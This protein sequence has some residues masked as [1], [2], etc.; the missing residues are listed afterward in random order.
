MKKSDVSLHEKYS[1]AIK[2]MKEAEAKPRGQERQDL[3]MVSRR[4]FEEVSNLVESL[5]IFSSNELL[6]DVAS[7]DLKYMLVPFHIA[8]ILISSEIGSDRLSVFK[9][10]KQ[11]MLEFLRIAQQYKIYDQDNK[12]L[13]AEIEKLFD[14][15][16]PSYDHKSQITLENAMEMRNLKIENY[17]KRKELDD[18]LNQLEEMLNLGHQIEDEIVREYY[19]KLLQRSVEDSVESLKNEIRMGLMFESRQEPM[20]SNQPSDHIDTKVSLPKGGLTIV[21]DQEQKKVFGLGYPSKPTLTVDEFIGQ[22]IKSGDLAFQS[23]KEIYSNSLQRYAEQP[24]L[25]RDQ[26]EEDVIVREYKEDKDDAEEIERKRRWDEFKDDNPR[27]SG[28][29]HNMG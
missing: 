18:R 15:D 9:Q 25:R 1:D 12:T 24:N 10:A 14:D 19:V 22:K 20:D 2:F 4:T 21:K 6:E 26:E 16:D 3:Y 28:N 13:K 27:G 11:H 7:Y 23:Q 29:R 17:R 8:R 5:S